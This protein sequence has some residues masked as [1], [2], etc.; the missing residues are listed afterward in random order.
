MLR[1]RT[2]GTLDL[3][4]AG[5]D[6]LR[7]V[8]AQPKRLALL[9]YLAIATPRGFHQRDKLLALFWAERDTDRARAAL[10]RATYFL[11]RELGDDIIISRGDELGLD[12]NRLWCD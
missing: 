6:E 10:N 1:L 3:R 7:T 8:V 9:A 4:R 5:G 12:S 2:F 11:R